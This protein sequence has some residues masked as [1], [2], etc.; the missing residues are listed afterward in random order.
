MA[1]DLLAQFLLENNIKTYYICGTY[2]DFSWEDNQSHA[3]LLADNDVVIDI[4]GDQF[5]HDPKFLN[6]NKTVYVGKNDDFHRL[7]KVENRDIRQ[8]QKID[9]LNNLCQG[10]L[11]EIYKKIITYI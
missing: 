1:S 10:E 11:Y 8:C 7:F 3:W 2:R 5:K 9:F 4:T 6:Y